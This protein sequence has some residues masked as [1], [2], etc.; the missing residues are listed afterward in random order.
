MEEEATRKLEERAACIRDCRDCPLG[1]SRTN[2][3]PGEGPANARVM[4]IAEGPGQNEDAQGRPFVGR[5][6]E[7]LDDL[8]PLAELGRDEVFITNMLKCQAPGNRDP[9]AEEI[10]ACDKH[11]EA[12]LEIIQPELIVTLGRF[13]LAK[14]LPRETIG[15]ARGQLRHR[16]GRFIFPVMHPAAGLRRNE[17]RDRVVEDFLAIPEA[18]R[19]VREDPPP[20]EKDEP[21]GPETVQTSLF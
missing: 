8:L 17:F 16:N 3:V 21:R 18:L 5:A 14:F 9:S 13:S 2:A 20:E 15:K 12:Q 4:F 19:R 6:G 1:S 11:L 7:F 10:M